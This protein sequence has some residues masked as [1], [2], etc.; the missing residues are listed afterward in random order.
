M[1]RAREQKGLDEEIALLR[2]M[3]RRLVDKTR[4]SDEETAKQS[5]KSKNGDEEKVRQS[6]KSRDNTERKR[7]KP[8][9]EGLVLSVI[10]TL[11]RALLAQA[12]TGGAD[13]DAAAGRLRAALKQL[14]LILGEDGNEG[15]ETTR[16]GK[17]VGEEG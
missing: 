12:R 15:P 5:A 7:Q 14:G 16:N 8:I 17:H 11:G 10:N 3:L 2:V 4:D 6:G 13:P 1:R 9:D